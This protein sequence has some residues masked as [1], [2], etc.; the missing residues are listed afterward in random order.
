VPGDFSKDNRPRRAGAY[1]QFDARQSVPPPPGLG[2][3]VALAFTGDWG[4]EETPTLLRSFQDYRAAFGDSIT[5]QGY[6]AV[7]QAFQGEGLPGFGGA[8]AVLAYRMTGS[9]GAKATH[10]FQ[11]TTPA[12]AITINAK[13]PGT[14]GNAIN[15][16]VQDQAGVQ[17][18]EQDEFIVYDGATEV[19]RYVY[20]DTDIA[21]LVSQINAKS[22]WLSAVQT[23]T[24]VALAYVANVA[25]TGGN[26]GSTLIA[27]DYTTM[28]SALEVERFSVLS[29]ECPA[30]NSIITSLGVWGKNARA[31]GKRFRTVIGG[32]LDEDATT[33]IARSLLLND[34]GFIN[35]GGG[36]VT[37]AVLGVLSTAQLAPRVAGIVAARGEA[38]G[39]TYARFAGTT[40]RVGLTDV[41]I[42]RAYDGGVVALARDSNLDAPLRIEKGVNTYT[43]TT[44]VAKPLSIFRVPKFVATM[45][46]IQMDLTEFG[47]QEVIGKMPVSASTRSFV[48]SEISQMMT[49]REAAGI[50]QPGWTVDVDTDPPA[51]PQDDFMQF[52]IGLTF[53]R[54]TEQIF[55]S[56]SVG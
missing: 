29:F 35:V 25:L 19:E 31:N 54:S 45:D 49:Q 24:G 3:I 22:Q 18:P 6:R 32:A 27:G 39:L 53:G 46:G 16:T 21:S 28:M 12:A 43:T 20:T 26:D 9:A 11:N 4:P 38:R 7:R 5:T 41:D 55:F 51:T 2:G 13:Y 17:S 34:P 33:A 1:F 10:V 50:I 42:L 15:I 52:I 36:S 47:E 8:G 56:A 37:D 40:L 14:R 30:D 23:V 44:N 48:R